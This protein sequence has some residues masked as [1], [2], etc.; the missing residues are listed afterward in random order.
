MQT[1][2]IIRQGAVIKVVPPYANLL[3]PYL[4]YSRRVQTGGN[5]KDADYVTTR[6]YEVAAGAGIETGLLTSFGLLKHV[7]GALN[8]LGIETKYEDWSGI[9][10][11]TAVPDFSKLPDLRDLQPE[12]LASIVANEWGIIAAPTGFGKTFLIKQLTSIW[13]QARFIICC[14]YTDVIVNLY[15][16]LKLEYRDGEV[17]MVGAGYK[18]ADCR[19]TCCVDKSLGRCD[20]GHC[21]CFIFDE[22][23]RAASPGNAATI[24]RLTHARRYAFSASWKG[25]SDGADL[26]TIAL[27]GDLICRLSYK[28]VEKVGAVVPVEVRIISTAKCLPVPPNAN[29]VV[30]NRRGIWRNESRNKLL[31]T[32]VS[33]II[34]ELGEETQVLVTVATIDHAV[35]LQRFL[36][37]FKIVYGSM[38]ADD[39]VRWE[40]LGWLKTGEHPISQETR[41]RM[42]A[43]FAAGSLKRVIATGVW[44]TG[45][46]FPKLTVLV[47]ADSQSGSIPSTQLPGRVTRTCEGKDRGIVLDCDDLM[48]P[49]LARRAERRF[50]V[51]RSKGWEIARVSCD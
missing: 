12:V 24:A 2:K 9:N 51:Y 42:H 19:I 43:D 38:D 8:H 48:N 49:T 11:A 40:R 23:H 7:C 46:N 22:A 6:L 36:P 20:L 50:A 27:L 3:A 45:A 31:A 1:A 15:R 25:R 26:E 37:D 18:E 35:N 10:K 28:E 5:A 17:G 41:S 30:L 32:A 14:P 21:D 13:P 4:T 47:R 33:R 34:K 29:S 39:R 44:G 16:N